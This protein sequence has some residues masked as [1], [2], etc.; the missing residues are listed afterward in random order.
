MSDCFNII[1]D[2]DATPENAEATAARI[3]AWLVAE[4][5]I[6][7]EL[8]DCGMSGAAHAPGPNAQRL[9]AYADDL[10][11]GLNG[12]EI[13]VDPMVHLNWNASTYT[14]TCPACMASHSFDTS[15]GDPVGDV[16]I[17]WREHGDAVACP[18][19]GLRDDI[20]AFDWG[21]EVFRSHVWVQFWNWVDPRPE[22]LEAAIGHRMRMMYG[23]L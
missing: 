7:A 1:G 2:L 17:R 4:G 9:D 22:L 20:N 15:P 21:S 18:A 11:P 14:M 23:N 8:T 16:V 3:T 10:F 19:C 12:V 13:H 5:I 6:E